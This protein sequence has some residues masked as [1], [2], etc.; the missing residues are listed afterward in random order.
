MKVVFLFAYLCRVV[1]LVRHAV[2]E[3]SL[4]KLQIDMIDRTRSHTK[5]TGLNVEAC[6]CS[7]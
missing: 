2:R 6:R 4:L 3:Y 7:R 5:D 1:P